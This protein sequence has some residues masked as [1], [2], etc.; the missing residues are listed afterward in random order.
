MPRLFY[1]EILQVFELKSVVVYKHRLVKAESV[2][3]TLHR[4]TTDRPQS[5]LIVP[6][7]YEVT[8][9]IA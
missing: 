1:F 9:R 8:H 4:V 5:R 2:E 7:V 3:S 6:M